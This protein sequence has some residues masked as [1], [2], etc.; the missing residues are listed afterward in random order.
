MENNNYH[1]S[2]LVNA[3]SEAVM[4]KIGQINKWW[5]KDF[6]Q[7]AHQ[8]N[9]EF[10][11]PFGAPAFVDFVITEIL[12]N[13]KMVWKVSDCHLHWFQDKKE[14]NNTELVFQLTEENGKTRID[15]THVGLVP[16]LECYEVCEKGWNGHI[17]TLERFINEGRGLNESA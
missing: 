13:K 7:F 3:T 2:I 4:H 11:I 10:T 5:I 17:S 12:P 9:Q 8:L 6:P 15:I 1:R 16:Q 14:W